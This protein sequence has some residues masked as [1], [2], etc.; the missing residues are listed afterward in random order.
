MIND[1][2]Y[3]GELRV[4]Q[5]HL[6]E[7]SYR[8]MNMGTVNPY[9]AFAART[10]R[11]NVY[12]LRVELKSFPNSVPK[13]FVTK[14][15]KNKAGADM[16]SPSAAMHT[17]LSEHGWT[18]ICHYGALSW[19]PNVSL[20]KIFIKC[21]LWLEMYEMHLDTGKNIDFYLNHQV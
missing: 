9:V 16:N 8:F 12:T 19:T 18:R 5:S 14:M 20:Y 6:P 15:L 11:G 7:N 10:N 4:L 3:Q 21:R 2:R 1:A 17:L 13:V